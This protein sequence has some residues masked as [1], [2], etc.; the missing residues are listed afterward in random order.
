MGQITDTAFTTL[1]VQLLLGTVRFL[2]LKG[3][4]IGLTP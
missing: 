1:I 3:K 2:C 4:T